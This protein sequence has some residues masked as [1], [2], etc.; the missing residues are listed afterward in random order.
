MNNYSAGDELFFFGFSRGAY[1]VRAC[2]GLVC[3][4]GI[5]KPRAMGQFW[6]MYANYKS[7]DPST[8]LEESAWGKPWDGEGAPKFTIKVKG[9]DWEFKKGSGANWLGG[10]IKDVRIK[11]VGVWDTVG[12][13]GYPDNVWV[14]T[15]EKNKPYGFHNTDI[16]ERKGIPSL[17]KRYTDVSRNRKCVPCFSS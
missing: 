11:V 7:I 2:A 8:P 12:S 1:T 17:L 10:A 13:L 14:D 4:A 9:E 5:C 15:R 6:E 3:R 16:H